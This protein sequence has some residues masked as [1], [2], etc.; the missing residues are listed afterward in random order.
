MQHMPGSGILHPPMQSTPREGILQPPNESRCLQLPATICHDRPR[1][2]HRPAL[3]DLVLFGE[4]LL[5][6]VGDLLPELL[7]PFDG[8]GLLHL[9]KDL[10]GP[11]HL[12]GMELRCPS[13]TAPPE[14]LQLGDGHGLHAAQSGPER[15][16][17][18]FEELRASPSH[19][20]VDSGVRGHLLDFG[21][22]PGQV[23]TRHFVCHRRDNDCTAQSGRPERGLQRREGISQVHRRV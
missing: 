16:E 5:D 11:W 3:G 6:G 17:V 14:I 10:L 13:V 9:D 20:L 2:R 21:E 7:L 23:T 1:L 12:R 18:L 15:G 8:V 4:L 19:H 22:S